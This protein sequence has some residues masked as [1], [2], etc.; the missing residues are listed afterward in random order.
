MQ[1]PT[2]H[3]GLLNVSGRAI[4]NI[5]TQPNISNGGIYFTESKI[6]FGELKTGDIEKLYFPTIIIFILEYLIN[7]L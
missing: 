3:Y 2:N 6:D 5:N 1:N 4:W 7:L